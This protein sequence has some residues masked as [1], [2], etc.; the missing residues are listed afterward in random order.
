MVDFIGHCS[1]NVEKNALE[2]DLTGVA[3]QHCQEQARV[4]SKCVRDSDDPPTQ[5]LDQV[6]GF[7]NCLR[8]RAGDFFSAISQKHTARVNYLTGQYLRSF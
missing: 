5:C 2:F 7:C 3:R 4:F 1:H 6:Q 8:A